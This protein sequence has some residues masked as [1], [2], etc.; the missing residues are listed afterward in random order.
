MASFRRLGR[1]LNRPR[2]RNLTSRTFRDRRSLPAAFLW[3]GAE[4]KNKNSIQQ[5]RAQGVRRKF[6]PSLRPSSAGAAPQPV[7]HR[8]RKDRTAVH[9]DVHGFKTAFRR[10]L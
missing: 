1:S 8:S 5:Q 2:R 7:G 3:I 6:L 4:T 9:P 10:H